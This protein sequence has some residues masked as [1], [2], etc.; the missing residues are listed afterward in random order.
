MTHKQSYYL[1]S[2]EYGQPM[3]WVKTKHEADAIVAIYDGWNYK[4][5]KVAKPEVDLSKF[6]D[7]LF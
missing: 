7:A 1:I 2:D 3:R 4:F 6:E 5:L